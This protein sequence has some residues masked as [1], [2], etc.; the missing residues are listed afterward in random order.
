M[1]ALIITGIICFGLG[2]LLGTYQMAAV[3]AEREMHR[4]T[5]AVRDGVKQAFE[6]S[7]KEKNL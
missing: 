6:K 2:W 7:I 1:I 3:Y 4:L 5:D